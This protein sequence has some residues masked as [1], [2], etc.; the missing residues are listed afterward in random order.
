[1]DITSLSILSRS[2]RNGG[3][4]PIIS[5]GQVG[6]QVQAVAVTD[7][8]SLIVLAIPLF[9]EFHRAELGVVATQGQV[10]ELVSTA[11]ANGSRSTFM[12]SFEHRHPAR[13]QVLSLRQDV[14]DGKYGAII[15]VMRP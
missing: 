15:G 10:A 4:V 8:V 13:P 5:A 6:I 1:M 7:E 9:Q 14:F 3:L 2:R 11:L 12:I